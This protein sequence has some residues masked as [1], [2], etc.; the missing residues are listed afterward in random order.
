[1]G[2]GVNATPLPLYFRYPFYRT[3]GGTQSWAGQARNIL[4]PQRF[5]PRTVQPIASRYTD[6]CIPAHLL[7]MCTF[8]YTY[9]TKTK[10][11]DP[12]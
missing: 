10:I 1:M 5:D 12:R 7:K 2:L 11:L 3:L 9:L 8:K 6:C 4:P